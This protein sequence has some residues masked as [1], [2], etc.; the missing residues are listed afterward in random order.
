MLSIVANKIDKDSVSEIK[1]FELAYRLNKDLSAVLIWNI[2]VNENGN[3]RN[4]QIDA[5]TGD[6]YFE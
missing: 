3:D 5:V 1:L 6:V 4:F 2:V